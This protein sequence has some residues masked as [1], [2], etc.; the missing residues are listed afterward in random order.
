MTSDRGGGPTRGIVARLAPQAVPPPRPAL[1]RQT[2]RLPR[3]GGLLAAP[4]GRARGDG[5]LLRDDPCQRAP[6]RLRH[7]RGG[8]PPV[9]RGPPR[10]GRF[11]R[12]PAARA[13]RSSSP[14]TPP[15]SLNLVAHSYGRHLLPEG[16]AILLTEL[17]HHANL[18][19]WLMLA[20]ERGVELRYI[21][22]GEDYRLDLSG[23]DGFDGRGRPR[24]RLL[25]VQRARHHHRPRPDRRCRPRR[26]CRCRRR[27]LPARPPPPRRRERARGRLP[28]LHGPQDARADRHRGPLGP[29]GAARADAAFP[30]RGRDDP[31]RAP[32]RLQRRTTCP[33]SSRR[34]RPRSQR[35]SG[36]TPRSVSSRLWAWSG[37]PRTRPSSPSRAI[38]LLARA[39]RRCPYDLRAARRP[40]AP[41][42]GRLARSR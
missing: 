27:R 23:L 5:P 16:K 40:G 42:R 2:A 17:E 10:R 37:S 41:R 28:R 34:A 18:V 9:R 19:P 1:A 6:R 4:A 24:R 29:R 21:P 20:A 30:R 35:R 32:R 31:R 15:R 39:P 13:P 3:L 12:R 8:D 7:R 26:R 36:C 22:L 11:V 25:H 14:R 38:E 33:G